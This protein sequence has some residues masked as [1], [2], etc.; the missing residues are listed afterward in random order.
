LD[1]IAVA[2]EEVIA[3][4][5]FPLH[6]AHVREDV[7]VRFAREAINTQKHKEK[8]AA[9]LI[10][11]PVASQLAAHHRPNGK[12]LLQFSR[13]G[14]G[15]RLSRLDFASRKLPFER[16]SIGGMPLADKKHSIALDER[17]NHYNRL[18]I[19]RA[20]PYSHAVMITVV[21]ES[22]YSERLLDHFRNPRKAGEL[23]PPSV[24]AEVSN[25]ACGDVLRLS[26][27]IEN[28]RI[29]DARFKA[30]GCTA[31][32]AAGS[33]LTEW[34]TGRTLEEVKQLTPGDIELA[35][36]GLPDTSK[37][38]AVLAVETAQALVVG[39]LRRE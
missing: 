5:V 8:R 16:V 7:V 12:L 13:Q 23:E 35:L 11:V 14:A 18:P 26:A 38:A 22:V 25:P 10:L 4:Q 39:V 24:S 33:A 1:K 3:G 17:R 20:L 6:P 9:A 2:V 15:V 28:G 34:I 21:G 31:S 19:C 29:L 27:R 36:G 30:R 37:H 32:I